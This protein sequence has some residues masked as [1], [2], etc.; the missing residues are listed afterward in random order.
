MCI[1]DRPQSAIRP[2]DSAKSLQA[3]EPGTVRAKER[4]QHR[5]PELPRDAL[6][7]TSRADSES[8]H[9]SGPRGGSKV[10]NS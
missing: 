4:P 3:F 8:A 10:A 9:A 1:R 5:P 6:R 2:V 7:A